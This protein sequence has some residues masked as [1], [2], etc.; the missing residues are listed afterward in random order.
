M[1]YTTEIT[2]D[3]PR[4]RLIE[5]FDSADNLAEW[6]PGLQRVEHLSG[7]AGQ[8]GAT[9]RLTYDMG[10]RVVEMIETIIRRNLPDEFTATY[11]ARGV[12][13]EVVNRFYDEGDQTRWVAEAAFKFSG[14]MAL[15]ALFSPGAFRKQSQ[16]IMQNFKAFAERA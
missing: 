9:S 6:Q 16:E 8:A 15:M 1:K 12:W 7:E 2:I 5:L 11:E 14:F 3:L 13:N 4:A 10:G